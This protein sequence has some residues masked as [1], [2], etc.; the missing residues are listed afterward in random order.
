MNMPE[1]RITRRLRRQA[2]ME[3]TAVDYSLVQKIVMTH[4]APLSAGSDG[5]VIERND[6]AVTFEIPVSIIINKEDFI[7]ALDEKYGSADNLLK[8]L[9]LSFT[10]KAKNL[11]NNK[12][13]MAQK[14]KEEL[15]KAYKKYLAENV[16]HEGKAILKKI[17]VNEVQVL[18]AA[19]D[20]VHRFQVTV[21]PSVDLKQK[22]TSCI[23]TYAYVDGEDAVWVEVTVQ[24]TLDA[25]QDKDGV[26]A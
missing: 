2:M 15:W 26:F 4:T 9:N 5:K 16:E 19:M 11:F 10:D 22:Y 6:Q 21:D 12:G 23:Y 24:F 13:E 7:K 1:N 20:D 14:Y 8:A 17:G 3:R 18:K 25:V